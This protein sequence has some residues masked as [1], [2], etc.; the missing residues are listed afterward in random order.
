[1]QRPLTSL[2]A[3]GLLSAGAYAHAQSSVTLYGIV[4]AGIAY[5][6]DSAGTNGANQGSQLRFSSGTMSGSRWGL[7]G[8]EQLGNG[9]QAVFQLE[10]GFNAGTG[11]FNQGGREFGRKAI[12]GLSST[13]WGTLTLGRQYD[14]VVDLVQ[15]LTGD[16]YFSGTFATPGDIDNYDNSS[17]ISNALKFTS[18][19]LHGFSVEAM[20]AFGGTA[21]SVSN[22]QTYSLGASYANGPLGLAAGYFHANG[23][24]TA[25]NGVR[26][27][28]GSADTLFNTAINS[29]YGSA[30][31]MQIVR[32]GARYQL[33][34]LTLG[35]SYSNI[36]YGRDSLSTFGEDETFN[37][38]ALLVAYTLTPS[39]RA[40][41]GYNYTKS[42]GAASAHYQQLNLGYDH[43]LSKQTDLY[44]L[45]AYQ[46]AGGN[47]LSASGR[48]IAADASIGSYGINSGSDSQALAAIGVRHRF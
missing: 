19:D 40:G 32:A 46:K 26:T 8:S 42:G 20:Y 5:V 14:P 43:A 4:D 25:A 6:H 38:G 18:P 39:S 9:L 13:R 33:G 47:T 2:T 29:G 36:R 12:V 15:P 23:G 16:A 21:G 28:S 48:S 11:T 45:A 3:I 31:S 37:S 24:S 27:W 34:A 1:M 30:K 35:A 10:N 41:F 22:G 17:R 7:R 44:L